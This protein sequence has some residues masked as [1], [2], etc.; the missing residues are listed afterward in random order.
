MF[1]SSVFGRL[2]GFGKRKRRKRYNRGI[3]KQ[4]GNKVKKHSQIKTRNIEALNPLMKTG[5]VHASGDK[6]MKKRKERKQGKEKLRKGEW[7]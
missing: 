7:L 4:R 5:G 1:V 2:S 6:T 3:D